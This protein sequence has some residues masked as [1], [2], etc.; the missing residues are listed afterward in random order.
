[1]QFDPS[2]T[3]QSPLPV[4]SVPVFEGIPGSS[5]RPSTPPITLPFDFVNGTFHHGAASSGDATGS[6]SLPER[7]KKADTS[8]QVNVAI[9]SLFA[10]A[11]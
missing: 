9:V 3:F 6:L 4:Q 7:P 1:M 2:F 10:Q 5:F 8:S 11:P